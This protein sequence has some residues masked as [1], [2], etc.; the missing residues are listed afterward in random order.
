L[1]KK[2]D[3]EERGPEGERKEGRN[4]VKRTILRQD[5]GFGSKKVSGIWRSGNANL[6]GNLR[7]QQ[8]IEA[9]KFSQR[10]I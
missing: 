2:D 5:K 8:W 7:Q 10:R 4:E 3:I 9:K 6:N 1:S